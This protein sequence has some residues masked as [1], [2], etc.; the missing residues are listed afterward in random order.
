MNNTSHTILPF[1][2]IVC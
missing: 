2:P 1:N